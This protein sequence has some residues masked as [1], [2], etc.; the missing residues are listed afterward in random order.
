MLK[1]KRPF[2][3]ENQLENSSKSALSLALEPVTHFMDLWSA[4]K[5]IVWSEFSTKKKC[6]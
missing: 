3:K 5:I 2:Q 1:M 4:N 6:F